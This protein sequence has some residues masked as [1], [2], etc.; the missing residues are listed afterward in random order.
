LPN[1][2]ASSRVTIARHLGV[3]W[4]ILC[5]MLLTHEQGPIR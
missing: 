3:S 1:G 4:R 2:I 5:T